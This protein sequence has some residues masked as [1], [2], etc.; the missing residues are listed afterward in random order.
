MNIDPDLRMRLEASFAPLNKIA[1][2][3]A[4]PAPMTLATQLE[5]LMPSADF[6]GPSK[7]GKSVSTLFATAAVDCWLR[8]I[9]GFLTSASLTEA[10]P[11]WSSVSGYYSS[12]YC[13]R[14]FAHLL[15]YFQ[16]YHKKRNVKMEIGKGGEYFCNFDKKLGADREHKIYWKL[17]KENPHFVS[18]PLFAFNNSDPSIDASDAG[19]RERMNYGDHIGLVPLFRNLDTPALRK[20]VEYIS[21]IEFTTPPI[22]KRSKAPDIDSV[23]VVAY[24]RI[25]FFR[26][27][28]DEIL[29]GGNRFWSVHR[30]PSWVDGM[31]DF[32]LTEQGSLA[33]LK[34]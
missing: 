9:H 33:S 32:Q 17:V 28:L 25:V 10:S 22:P 2:S 7:V 16:L 30:T 6:V 19:H 1:A 27:F 5:V 15:G 34:N 13:V 14:G 12:H 18:E 24:H 26:R 20:R 23:Q 11:V 31:T 8:G 4:F 21:Q 3:K 29:G